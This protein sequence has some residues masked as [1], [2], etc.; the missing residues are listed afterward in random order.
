MMV[1][2]WRLIAPVVAAAALGVLSFPADGSSLAASFVFLTPTGPSPAALTIPAGMYPVW[3]NQDAVTHTVTFANGACSLQIAPG[4]YAQCDRFSDLVGD[5]GY[6]VDGK[7]QGS[8]EVRA[9]GRTVTLT[10]PRHRV[11]RGSQLRLQG[12]LVAAS[13]SPPSP[14]PAQPVIVLAR[15]DRMHPFHRIAVVRAKFHRFQGSP[16][17]VLWQLRVRPRTRAIY[18]AE[19]NSQP[20]GGKYWQRP[21]SRPVKILVSR[22]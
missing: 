14:G 8:I 22:Y 13:P 21:W 1:R 4:G 9:E 11:G 19:A 7:T 5:Y 17:A 16:G 10:T 3:R 6:T 12:A 20:A 15:H 2:R 18:I